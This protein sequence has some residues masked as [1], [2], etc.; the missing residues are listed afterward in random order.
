MLKILKFEI[1]K[2]NME[3]TNKYIKKVSAENIAEVI[4][5]ENENTWKIYGWHWLDCGCGCGSSND[6]GCQK[7]GK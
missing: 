3:I 2:S 6:S 1:F 4:I 7:H 5:D